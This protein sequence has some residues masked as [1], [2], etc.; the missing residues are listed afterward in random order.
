MRCVA[1]AAAPRAAGQPDQRARP[2]ELGAARAGGL[3]PTRRAAQGVGLGEAALHL[4]GAGACLHLED[5]LRGPGHAGDDGPARRTLLRARGAAL[6]VAAGCG[7][8]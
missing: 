5:A 2:A 1:C 4:E 3:Q 7:A 6:P 8:G